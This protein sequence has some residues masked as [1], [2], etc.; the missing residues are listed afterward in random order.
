MV[1]ARDGRK[2][3]IEF[4]TL[5]GSDPPSANAVVASLGSL[6]MFIV[7]GFPLLAGKVGG[8]SVIV[9]HY[10]AVRPRGG[11]RDVG[12]VPR[13]CQVDAERREPR[14]KSVKCTTS[15]G[16]DV[17]LQS[18]RPLSGEIPEFT[19]PFNSKSRFALLRMEDAW[20]LARRKM[21]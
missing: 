5:D 11:S 1:W 17:W 16:D 20:I 7:D 19:D 21:S 14:R 13:M 8:S 2:G 9:K 10:A 6:N 15:K 18:G 4:E 12:T 3:S